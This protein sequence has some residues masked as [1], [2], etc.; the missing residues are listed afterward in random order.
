MTFRNKIDTA[1][2]LMTEKKA[3]VNRSCEGE[4]KMTALHV[5]KSAE[6]ITALLAHGAKPA[7]FNFRGCNALMEQ[8]AELRVGCVSA[9]LVSALLAHP[10][11][12][13]IL[14]AQSSWEVGRREGGTALHYAV[15]PDDEDEPC[16]EMVELLLKAGADAWILNGQG[17][18]AF[19][20]LDEAKDYDLEH[21]AHV[22]LAEAMGIEDEEED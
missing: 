22:L 18:S 2:W 20:A 16:E 4:G 7:V 19:D 1:N 3:D 8:V 14:N 17:Y 21:P 12:R 5:A 10:K 13:A 6:M 11:G 9:L 15:D